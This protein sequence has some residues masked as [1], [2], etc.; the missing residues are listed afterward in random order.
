MENRQGGAGEDDHY[1][2]KDHKGDFIIGQGAIEALTEFCDTERGSDKNKDGG[3]SKGYRRAN[4]SVSV[5]HGWESGAHPI[6]IPGIAASAST[7]RTLALDRPYACRPSKRILS[8]E[9]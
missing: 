9:R 6:E 8:R 5:K 7:A 4:I 2:L 1:A 3:K